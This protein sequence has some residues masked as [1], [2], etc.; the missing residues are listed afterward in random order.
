MIVVVVLF[1]RGNAIG[2]KSI[3]LFMILI[4]WKNIFIGLLLLFDWFS[5]TVIDFV[6]LQIYL[7][8]FFLLVYDSLLNYHCRFHCK[9]LEN[10][11][12]QQLNYICLIQLFLMTCFIIFYNLKLYCEIFRK[13]CEKKVNYNVHNIFPWKFQVYTLANT[14]STNAF[15]FVLA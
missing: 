8:I 14:D 3:L 15:N 11:F 9:F 2:R 5:K 1:F 6:I 13:Y 7:Y 12:I 10:W 4:Y